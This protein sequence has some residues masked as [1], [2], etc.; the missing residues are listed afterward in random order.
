MLE[1]ETA[2]LYKRVDRWLRDK[3]QYETDDGDK[4]CRL[5]FGLYQIHRDQT[6]R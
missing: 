4:T 1:D 5:G 2:K 3:K 6:N